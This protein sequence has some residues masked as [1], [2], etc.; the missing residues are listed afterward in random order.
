MESIFPAARN[1]KNSRTGTITVM[2]KIWEKIK[3]FS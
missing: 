2:I 3:S 1:I